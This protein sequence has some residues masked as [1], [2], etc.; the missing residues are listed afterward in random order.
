MTDSADSLRILS[1]NV[2]AGE[3]IEDLTRYLKERIGTISVFCFQEIDPLTKSALDALLSDHYHAHYATKP[4]DAGSY[5]LA[6]YVHRELNVTQ[7]HEILGD[8][9]NAGLGLTCQIEDRSCRSYSVTN[10]HGAS[11]PGTKLDNP[12]RLLQSRSLVDSILTGHSASIFIGDF[13]LLPE[14][15]SVDIFRQRGYHD[16]IK[17]FEIPTT[18]NEVVWKRWPDNKQLFADYAFVRGSEDLEYA[19]TVDDVI[20]SDHLPLELS[21][22]LQAPAEAMNALELEATGEFA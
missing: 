21:L 10:V 9:P 4:Y 8:T 15:E 3:F 18:R 19:F 14:T 13:N 16:L 12:A 6:T 20:L 2:A 17:E 5:F 7:V 11:Q 1:L 22:R